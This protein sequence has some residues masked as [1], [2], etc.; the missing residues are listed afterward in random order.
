[1]SGCSCKFKRPYLNYTLCRVSGEQTS[2]YCA[3]D[4]AQTACGRI[5]ASGRNRPTDSGNC[6]QLQKAF[7]FIPPFPPLQRPG[8]RVRMHNVADGVQRVR[9]RCVSEVQHRNSAGSEAAQIILPCRRLGRTKN[10]TILPASVLDRILHR[11]TCR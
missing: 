2:W 9:R 4:R 6:F 7:R 1:M 11:D 3:A 5:N 10:R 8:F